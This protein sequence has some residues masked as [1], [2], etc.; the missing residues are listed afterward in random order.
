MLRPTQ[1]CFCSLIEMYDTLRFASID[2][3]ES[4]TFKFMSEL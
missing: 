4:I 2:G 1:L 3:Y